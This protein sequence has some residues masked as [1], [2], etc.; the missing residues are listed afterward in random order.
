MKGDGGG[1]W[2]GGG[3]LSGH[4]NPFDNLFMSVFMRIL[5]LFCFMVGMN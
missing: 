5:Y 2:G 3:F 4:F 1:G